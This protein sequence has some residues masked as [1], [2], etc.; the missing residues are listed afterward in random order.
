MLLPTGDNS[1][2]CGHQQAAVRCYWN[3]GNDVYRDGNTTS[4]CHYSRLNFPVMF[5]VVI[6]AFIYLF[7]TEIVRELTAFGIELIKLIV[8]TVLQQAGFALLVLPPS[9]R[10]ASAS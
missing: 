8:D 3:P 2:G 1:D 9:S 6:S 4:Q 7:F 10:L 5:I